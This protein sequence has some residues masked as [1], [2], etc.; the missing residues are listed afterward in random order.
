MKFVSILALTASVSA[1]ALPEAQTSGLKR[2]S[3]S[4]NWAGIVKKSAGVTSATGTMVMPSLPNAISD[5]AVSAWVGIDGWSCSTTALLQTGVDILADGTF[6]PW[7][8][9]YPS[10]LIKFT[11]FTVSAGDKIRMSVSV[12][13]TTAGTTKLENLST[14]KSK[15]H[16]YNTNPKALC[17]N[18]A[19]WILEDFDDD[20]T[21]IK[22]T[23][24]DFG[25][26][27]F[28][29]ASTAG[30]PATSPNGGEVVTLVDDNG[31]A[32]TSCSATKTSVSCSYKD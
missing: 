27:T 2:R 23:L 8:Q 12:T 16:V 4:N 18:E 21:G 19:V 22:K 28:T 15:S 30:G 13:N 14:G 17:Q 26:V 20:D 31:E 10:K 3:L 1:V 29:D 9:F 6:T 11:D 7:A 5:S 25:T 24:I 32:Q